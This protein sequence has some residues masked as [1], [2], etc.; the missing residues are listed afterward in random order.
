MGAWGFEPTDNDTAADWFDGLRDLG[1]FS[2]IES[3]LNSP[4]DC[5]IRAAGW[6]VQQLGDSFVYDVYKRE[7]HIELA[8]NKIKGLLANKPYIENWSD[9]EEIKIS[10]Q[11]QIKELES[12]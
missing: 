6:L 11:A 5:E 12:L 4:N 9:E 10:L 3:G 1:L 2:L 8:I 7:A